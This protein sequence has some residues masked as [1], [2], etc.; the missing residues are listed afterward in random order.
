VSPLEDRFQSFEL[1]VAKRR[2]IATC[3]FALTVQIVDGRILRKRIRQKRQVRNNVNKQ[4][5][6]LHNI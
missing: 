4:K 6:N 2:S 5:Y 1:S 3:P